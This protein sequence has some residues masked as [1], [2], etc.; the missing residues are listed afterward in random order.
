MI[1]IMP[2]LTAIEMWKD[3]LSINGTLEEEYPFSEW[4]NDNQIE[5]Q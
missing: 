1:E 3:E 4:C 5:P 2:E